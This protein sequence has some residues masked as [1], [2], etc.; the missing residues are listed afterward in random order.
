MK[1]LSIEQK[2]KAYDKALERAKEKYPTC[3]SPALL[4]YI[5]PELKESEDK[6]IRKD[7]ISNLKRYVNC[8][9]DG[10]DASSAKDFVVKEIEKQI[11]WLEKQGDKSVDIDIDIESMV[12]SYKQRLKAQSGIR[13]EN[14][15]LVNMC[16]TAFRHG[17]ENTLEE[18]NLK[19]LEKQYECNP[20]SG[21]SFDYNGH[22]WG[23]CARDGGVEILVDGEIKERV[24]LDNKP[25][26]KSALEAIREEN[27][28]NQNCGMPVDNVKPKIENEIEIPFGAKDSELQEVA[29]YIPKGFYAEIDNDKVII[30]KGEKPTA[31]NEESEH[32]RKR[33]ISLVNEVYNNTNYITFL[34][35]KELLA[36][37]EKL[38]DNVDL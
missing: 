6:E 5:F 32:I 15:P 12:S 8:I 34:E 13:M 11:A 35:H 25:Q 9:K 18:L 14:N 16:L 21:V 29:Y 20:Y 31:F 24:F 19:K 26:G 38:D 27:T 2:A 28:D 37:L 17:V 1:E 7:I 23:M 22:T 33:L 4:E 30:K 3:Y 36:W 10:Y